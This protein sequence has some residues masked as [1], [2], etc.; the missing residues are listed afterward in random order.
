MSLLGLDIGTTGV[1]CVAFD[2][3]GRVLA[4]AYREYPLY[5]PNPGWAELDADEVWAKVEAVLGEVASELGGDP[6]KGLAVSSQ[7][8]AGVLIDRQGCTLARSIISFDT[9]TTAEKAHYESAVGFERAFEITGHHIHTIY[10]NVKLMWMRRNLEDAWRR[11]WKFLCFEDYAGYRLT[12]ATAMDWSMCGRTMLFDVRRRD[13]SDEMLNA[14]GI[15]RELLPT[16][17]APGTEIGSVTDDAA[18]RLGLPRGMPVVAGAHDQP[19]AA[20]GAGITKAGVA[21]DG[22]GTVECITAALAEPVLNKV[23]FDSRL[24]CYNHAARDLYVTLGYN[25]TAGSL[26]RWYRDNLGAAES[27]E[28]ASR[29]VDPYDVMMEEAASVEGPTSLLVLP[30]FTNTGPPWFDENAKG[31]IL[32][33]KL[34]TKRR[35]LVKALIEGVTFE[36]KLNL[37]NMDA[38]GVP[39]EELRPMGGGAKSPVWMQLKAD[40]FDRPCVAMDVTEAGC[41]GVALLAGVAVGE[42]ASLGEGVS[43]TVRPRRTFEPDRER[44]RRYE[45]RFALYRELYPL[46]RDLAHRM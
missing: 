9:R 29:G 22:T 5:Y 46:P 1:K 14:G 8:E 3:D 34:E 7:G 6:P 24:C 21:V 32:G 2:P 43:A 18:S 44:A 10:T 4:S 17:V 20:L 42:Y 33:L 39:V 12:G 11:A 38:A 35:E 36:M 28:A 26:L 30:H 15:P 19:A 41:L 13:W 37:E 23:M 16:P 25:Y 31:A 27:A 40:I 45:E